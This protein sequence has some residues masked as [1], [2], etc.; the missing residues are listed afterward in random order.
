MPK[1]VSKSAEKARIWAMILSGC[2]EMLSIMRGASSGLRRINSTAATIS[3][4]LLLMSCR[5]VASFSLSS[6]TCSG[7]SVTEAWGIPM[8]RDLL[9]WVV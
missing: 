2:W 4:R 7:V 6:E 3:E 5:V 1:V 9:E 8:R